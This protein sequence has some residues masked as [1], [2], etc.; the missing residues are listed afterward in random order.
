MVNPKKVV[1]R[2]A[3]SNSAGAQQNIGRV[4]GHSVQKDCSLR[5]R[6]CSRHAEGRPIRAPICCAK[7][8]VV[9]RIDGNWTNADVLLCAP[10]LLPKG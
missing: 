10:I 1:Y 4:M 2:T 6:P 7:V 8:E 3:D 9:A 5:L